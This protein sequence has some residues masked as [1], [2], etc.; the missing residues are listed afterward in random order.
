MNEPPHCSLWWIH[1]IRG[2][3]TDL[4]RG[5]TAHGCLAHVTDRGYHYRKPIGQ[6]LVR[7]LPG[8]HHGP[9]T[10]DAGILSDC[11]CKWFASCWCKT[12]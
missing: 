11:I 5:V 3:Y 8:I 2:G 1:K 10:D 4:L 12:K 6:Y 7:L 9:F